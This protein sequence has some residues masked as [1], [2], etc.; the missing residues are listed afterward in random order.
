LEVG[1]AVIALVR[2]G[3]GRIGCAALR[4]AVLA[5]TVLLLLLAFRRS[6]ERLGRL[7]E[8]L[9]AS[10]RTN[11]VQQEMLAAAAR[12]PRDRGELAGRL[13]DGRSW[14]G[15]PRQSIR[16]SSALAPKCRRGWR[17]TSKLCRTDAE[18]LRDVGGGLSVRE[19]RDNLF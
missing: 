9:E 19:A 12:R 17:R 2:L 7:L 16:R 4:A 15:G 8:R 6:G 13:R 18:G 1:R 3:A 5:A 11:D 10:E 14:L